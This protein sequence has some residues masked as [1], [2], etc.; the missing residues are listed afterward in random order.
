MWSST[1][2]A[3][4]SS[5]QPSMALTSSSMSSISRGLKPGI[6]CSRSNSPGGWQPMRSWRQ[7]IMPP[8]TTAPFTGGGGNVS[9]KF[10]EMIRRSCSLAR[11]QIVSDRTSCEL[12]KLKYTLPGSSFWKKSK[13][14][15]WPG[16]FPVTS[17][18]Q[19]GGVSG[20][21]TERRTARVPRAESWARHGITPRSM[22]GSST[23]NVAPSRPISSVGPTSRL[24]V[25]RLAVRA[26]EHRELRD[27]QVALIDWAP[28][29]LLEELGKRQLPELLL[30]QRRE[31]DDLQRLE[32]EV[33]DEVRVRPDLAGELPVTLRLLEQREDGLEDMGI[34]ARHRA[35]SSLA[36]PGST[37]VAKTSSWSRCVRARSR[38]PDASTSSVSLPRSR[39]DARGAPSSPV[40]PTPSAFPAASL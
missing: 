34:D 18:V 14:P 6:C 26:N 8:G 23:V 16:C 21:M 4:S 40:R 30:D 31:D 22:Y 17:D 19:A 36:G 1:N 11:V 3:N 32:A 38:R 7:G 29:D 27:G 2:S 28:P 25:A 12:A 33:G 9:G 24:H 5:G 10:S 37:A 39:A 13:M 15:C 35:S 20:G